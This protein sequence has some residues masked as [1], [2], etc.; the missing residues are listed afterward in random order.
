MYFVM[1][2]FSLGTG[3][4]GDDRDDDHEQKPNDLCR[5]VVPVVRDKVFPNALEITPH[6]ATSVLSLCRTITLVPEIEGPYPAITR[7]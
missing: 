7:L 4:N 5:P 3:G 2:P 1:A 6:C